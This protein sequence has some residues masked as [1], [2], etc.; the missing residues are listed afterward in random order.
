MHDKVVGNRHVQE[1]S[2][3]GIARG[4]ERYEVSTRP[5]DVVLEQSSRY[6][7]QKTWTLWAQESET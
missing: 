3:K 6:L 1:Q 2:H 4:W 5:G 7:G